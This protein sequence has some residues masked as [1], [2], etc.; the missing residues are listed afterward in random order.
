MHRRPARH[1]FAR[2]P[3]H[4]PAEGQRHSLLFCD[5]KHLATAGE[6]IGSLPIKIVLIEPGRS[7][8]PDQARQARL[9]N[10]SN[11]WPIWTASLRRARAASN[12]LPSQRIVVASLLYTS[13]TTSDPKGVMLTHANLLGE[14]ESVFQLGARRSGRCRARGVAAVSRA[15]PDGESSAAAGEGRTR[16]LSGNIEHYRT[17][18]RAQRTPD[19]HL[20]RGAAIFLSDSRAHIQGSG[21]ARQVGGLGAEGFDD[22]S[23]AACARW[24]STPAESS[25]A[26]CTAPSATACAT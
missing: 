10:R 18:A 19:H 17:A 5:V 1:G 21:Q 23:I 14:V 8:K 26:S 15:L 22:A 13:G 2:R 7:R 3:D 9:P 4:H 20:C 16:G 6:A 24:D 12:P 25:S 11:R